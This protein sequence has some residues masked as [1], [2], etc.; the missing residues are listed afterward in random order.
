MED[1]AGDGEGEDVGPTVGVA[2]AEAEDSGVGVTD[3][4]GRADGAIAG[5]AGTPAPGVC[6]PAGALGPGWDEA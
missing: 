2:V 4:L 5:V 6:L 1:G 3:A